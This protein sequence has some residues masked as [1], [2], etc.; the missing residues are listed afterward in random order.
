MSTTPNPIPAKLKRYSM[1]IATVITATLIFSV[2]FSVFS[3]SLMSHPSAPILPLA[4]VPSTAS[5]QPPTL[6]WNNTFGLGISD[7][8]N[9]I[10]QTSDGGYAVFGRLGNGYAPV[11]AMLVKLDSSGVMLWNQTYDYLNS[12]IAVVQPSDGGYTVAGNGN[13]GFMLVKTDSKGT[14]LWNQTYTVSYQ[15]NKGGDALTMIQTSDGGYLIVGACTP[16]LVGEGSN[17]AFAL[18]TDSSGKMQ[19]SKTYGGSGID[20]FRSA[21]QISNGNYVLAGCTTSSGSGGFDAWLVETDSSRKQLW[22]KAFGAG[23]KSSPTAPQTNAAG[24]D[25]VNSLVQTGD[26]GFA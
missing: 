4:N 13:D 6:M 23:P 18:K 21:V 9:S 10:I 17:N 8:A 20:F 14:A 1:P 25:E 24:D 11:T 22:S 12:G 2:S 26:G 16:F 5:T 15:R 7:S 3:S 19:W